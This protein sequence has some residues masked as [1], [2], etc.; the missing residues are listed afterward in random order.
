M[1]DLALIGDLYRRYRDPLAKVRDAQRDLLRSN[2]GRLTPQLDDV[3]AEITYLLLRETRPDVVMELGALHGWSTTWI[4]SALRDNGSGFLHTF[5]II[6]NVVSNVPDDLSLGRWSFHKGDIREN[7]S[8]VP[9][10]IGYLFVDAAHNGRFA[11]WYLSELF[12]R[13]AAGTPVSV[14]DVFHGKRAL[15]F[16]EGAAVLSWLRGNGTEPFTVSRA[17]APAP[18]RALLELRRD[19]ELDE[20]VH[21]GTDNPMIYFRMPENRPVSP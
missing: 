18:H 2:R 4:L 7:L 13:V 14:H 20:P 10:G 3:E 6:D 12:P 1:V 15:P 8:Q 21:T 9:E 17:K 16:T 11:R 19:L 5:D